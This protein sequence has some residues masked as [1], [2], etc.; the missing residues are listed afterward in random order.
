MFR[1]YVVN[2]FD[3]GD[4]AR[5]VLKEVFQR[6]IAI[7]SARGVGPFADSAL[8]E[9]CCDEI[10][11]RTDSPEDG[12]AAV[13]IA[14]GRLAHVGVYYEV[15]GVAWVLHNSREAMQVVRHKVR[16]LDGAGFK[17]DGFYKWK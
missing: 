14:R 17:L 13:M 2:G 7:P 5:Q 15:N 1:P 8:V 11:V 12:D 9:R 6:D 4:L 3:C 10:G 16:E